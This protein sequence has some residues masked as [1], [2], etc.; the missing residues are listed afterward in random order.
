MYLFIQDRVS[1]AAFS[2]SEFKY[3]VIIPKPVLYKLLQRQ[4]NFTNKN[5][6]SEVKIDWN[7]Q[8]K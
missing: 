5:P 2:V 3:D 6:D 8:S 1:F 4:L 7:R